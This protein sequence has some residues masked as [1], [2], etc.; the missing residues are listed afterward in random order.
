MGVL[1]KDQSCSGGTTL[2]ENTDRMEKMRI[3]ELNLWK[4]MLILSDDHSDDNDDEVCDT[5]LIT[6]RIDDLEDNDDDLDKGVAREYITTF[7]WMA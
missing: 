4:H 2:A 1:D 6:N 3:E 5:K 7:L